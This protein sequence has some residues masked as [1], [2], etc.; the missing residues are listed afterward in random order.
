MSNIEMLKA[1]SD[2]YE[3]R[4]KYSKDIIRFTQQITSTLMTKKITISDFIDDLDSVKSNDMNKKVFMKKYDLLFNGTYAKFK[5]VDNFLGSYRRNINPKYFGVIEN[6]DIHR[7]NA[8]LRFYT[9]QYK[10]IDKK[11]KSTFKTNFSSR[12]YKVSKENFHENLGYKGFAK[13]EVYSLKDAWNL[14]KIRKYGLFPVQC[15]QFRLFYDLVDEN[16]N[17]IY[18]DIWITISS[19]YSTQKNLKELYEIAFNE[20]LQFIAKLE[21]SKMFIQLKKVC[22]Y[23]IRQ[24]H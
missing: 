15:V 5:N 18:S 24:G 3:K 8:E 10:K 14:N 2:D 9:T 7:F 12:N 23:V 21:Q 4:I 1:K 17:K 22:T 6:Q 20:V 16:G 19:K 13:N 11:I